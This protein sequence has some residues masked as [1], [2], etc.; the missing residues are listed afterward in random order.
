MSSYPSLSFTIIAV[1]GQLLK[2]SFTIIDQ[3]VFQ[4]CNQR[5][6][7]FLLHEAKHNG[8][9]SEEGISI[10]PSLTTTQMATIVGSSRQTVSKI[11]NSM[12]QEGL[13]VRKKDGRYLIPNPA[14]LEKHPF[15]E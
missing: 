3:L 15:K 6:T 4:D 13:L 9:T 1:L 2:Q 12:F 11:I 14:L 5:L 7:H 8:T 10:S